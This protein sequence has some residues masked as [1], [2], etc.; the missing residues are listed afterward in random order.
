MSTSFSRPCR[1][2][3][4][5]SDHH[6]FKEEHNVGRSVTDPDAVFTCNG[7]RMQG[8]D[9]DCANFEDDPDWRP[10]ICPTCD[11]SDFNYWDVATASGKCKNKHMIAADPQTR[12]LYNCAQSS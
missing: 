12:E 7:P 6:S 2:C 3:G 8:C 9:Q 5:L 4:H 1:R 11:T 10:L